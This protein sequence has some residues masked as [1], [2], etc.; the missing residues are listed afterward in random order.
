MTGIMMI[1]G[2]LIAS[3]HWL[4]MRSRENF[5]SLKARQGSQ[6]SGHTGRTSKQCYYLH[7]AGLLGRKGNWL[8]RVPTTGICTCKHCSH[9]RSGNEHLARIFLNLTFAPNVLAGSILD[10]GELNA[11]L[12]IHVLQNRTS[13]FS[14]QKRNEK[15]GFDPWNKHLK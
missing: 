14:S 11:C 4:L 13:L 10:L 2:K 7:A 8:L 12:D 5:C 1:N 6:A 15:S 9:P 3:L